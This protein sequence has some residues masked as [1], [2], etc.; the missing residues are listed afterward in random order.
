M[1][2]FSVVT[3]STNAAQLANQTKVLAFMFS[4]VEQKKITVTLCANPVRDMF[5]NS[6]D[7]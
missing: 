1:N 4:L 3:D 2:L 7:T 6:T 5:I